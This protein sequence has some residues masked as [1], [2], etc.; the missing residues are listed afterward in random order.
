MFMTFAVF[1]KVHR[2]RLGL[3]R[4]QSEWRIRVQWRSLHDIDL[5][6]PAGCGEDAK[7]STCEK[8]FISH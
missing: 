4:Q 2:R 8:R 7:I 6:V 3:T 5:R 1:Q